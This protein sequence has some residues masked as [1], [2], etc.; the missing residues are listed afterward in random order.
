MKISP[1]PIALG[2]CALFACAGDASSSNGTFSKDPLVT[3]T[4]DSGNLKIDVRTSPSQPPSRGEQAVQ[5]VVTDATTGKPKTGLSV[6][7][8]PW[9]PAMGHGASVTPSVSEKSP[10][11]YVI[12]D[13]DLFMPGNWELRTTFATAA[14]S[15][16]TDHAAPSFQI[17]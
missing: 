2:A 15:T 13:V 11:T 6:N 16:D 14:N 5:L 12:N 17:P 1:F 7:M 4:S 9:M 10:G 8:T 3:V